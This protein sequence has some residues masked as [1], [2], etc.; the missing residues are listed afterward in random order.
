M[1]LNAVKHLLA[2]FNFRAYS[3]RKAKMLKN[4]SENYAQYGKIN[5]YKKNNLRTLVSEVFKIEESETITS[6]TLVL[7][8][9]T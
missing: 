1:Y 8:S 2:N 9:L 5:W 6:L 7:K 4:E 3:L